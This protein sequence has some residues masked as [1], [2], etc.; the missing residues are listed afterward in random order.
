VTWKWRQRYDNT[1]SAH[2]YKSLLGRWFGTKKE[3][4]ERRQ[5]SLNGY[6]VVSFGKVSMF[7]AKRTVERAFL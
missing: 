2:K 6:F 1:G 7:C 4:Q 5:V 3:M